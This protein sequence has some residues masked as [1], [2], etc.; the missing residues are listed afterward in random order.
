[1]ARR[2]VRPLPRPRGGAG[3]ER[4]YAV[5]NVDV[6][7]VCEAPQHRPAPRTRCA[8]GWPSMLGIDIGAVSVKATT[9]EKLGFTGRGEGIA[10]QAIASSCPELKDT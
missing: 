7:I 10:A 2:V 8:R 3:R 5:G 1:M 6:T 9:T 4:G